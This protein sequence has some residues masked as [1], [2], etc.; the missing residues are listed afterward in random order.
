MVLMENRLC[1]FCG[2]RPDTKTREHVVPWWLL[3]MTGNPRRVVVFGQ[4]YAKRNKP[5]RYS[6][7]KFVAPAC[8][9]CNSKYAKLEGR[10]EP[11][12]KALQRR[13][14]LPV[15]AYIDLMDWLDK[16]RIGVWLLQHMIENHPIE[17]TP[18]FYISSR[19]AEK[20]RMLALYVF[21]SENKG[22]NLFGSDSLIFGVMPSCFG[23]RI[24]NLLLLNASSDFFC[25]KGCGLPH[26][27][28][29]KILMG[30][31]NHGKLQSEGFSYA[32]EIA[33]PITT[34]KLFK[35]VVWLYQPIK[36]PSSD[37]IFQA[38]YYG[39]TNLF[40]SRIMARTL[41]GNERQGA[42]FRQYDDRIE[43]LQDPSAVIELDQVVGDDCAMQKDIA[44][45]VYDVQVSLFRDLQYESI[46][47]AKSTEFEEEYRKIKI[48]NAMGLA[49]MYRN[50]VPC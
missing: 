11:S 12:I 38:G 28:S 2:Q 42:L 15:S 4:N 35:P 33:N 5:I 1:V 22:I 23:L 20:D 9:T 21:D 6:W 17:I 18:N 13:E 24:N 47:S 29:M 7:S 10:V 26:P 16:V 36:M 8:N 50:I 44:A 14:G 49:K 43:I 48:D 3:K 19:I 34:L 45:S 40:D 39:H 46:E 37:P 25:S 27:N 32:T 30:E 41:I 31:E